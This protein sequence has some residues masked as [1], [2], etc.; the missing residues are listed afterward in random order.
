[1]PWVDRID[2]INVVYANDPNSLA[3]EIVSIENTLGVMPQ[4]E[5]S[6]YLGNPV[7]YSTV[8]ARIS[9]TLAGTLHPYVEL[10][11]TD[12]Y[13]HNDERWNG[14]WGHRNVFNR[15]YDE[16]NCYNGT[17][18]TIP[19]SGLWYITGQQTWEWHDSGYCIHHCYINN[20][21][22]CGH[23]W[24]WNFG[25]A[26]PSHYDP[27]RYLTTYWSTLSPIPAGQPVN[28][29]SENGTSRNPYHVIS[30]NVRAY[31]LRKLPTSA[32]NT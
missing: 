4:V 27:T 6:P 10:N 9:D 28:I 12:F 25:S 8:D 13:C 17:D 21:W 30:S 31:C 22:R 11:A 14:N 32:L 5:K 24:D 1:M 20:N 3:A 19:C 2:L 16:Y 7:T 26:G 29:I 18:I 15:V 23:R